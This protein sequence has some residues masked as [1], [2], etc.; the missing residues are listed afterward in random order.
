MLFWILLRYIEYVMQNG[1][2][3]KDQGKNH[4]ITAERKRRGSKKEKETQKAPLG[5]LSGY[6]QK[7]PAL[8]TTLYASSATFSIQL[9]SRRSSWSS[10]RVYE[11]S[12]CRLNNTHAHTR[13][14]KVFWNIPNLKVTPSS[15]TP[16]LL[17]SK[18]CTG[19]TGEKKAQIS[20]NKMVVDDLTYK[21]PTALH[22]PHILLGYSLSPKK[23]K[24]ALFLSTR[25]P[26]STD[27]AEK[28]KGVK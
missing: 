15:N 16:V 10:K 21:W 7:E 24:F 25:A 4:V 13:E 26:N 5:V 14:L 12:H 9:K 27:Q 11:P 1:L 19:P 2:R 28:E 20:T 6:W 23:M 18:T 17:R 8:Y 22:F 3:I